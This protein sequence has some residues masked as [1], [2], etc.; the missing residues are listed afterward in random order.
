MIENTILQNTVM[1]H[2]RLIDI[3]DAMNVGLRKRHGVENI[4]DARN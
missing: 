3:V 2:Y 1:A 4:I